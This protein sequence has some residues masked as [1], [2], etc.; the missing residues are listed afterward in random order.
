MSEKKYTKINGVVNVCYL[1]YVLSIG[2]KVYSKYYFLLNNCS[3][4]FHTFNDPCFSEGDHVEFEVESY[5]GDSDIAAEK[6][7]NITRESSPSL[8]ELL[9]KQ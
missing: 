4:K 5:N 8:E 3:Q 7:K 1:P 6:F 2:D 9:K